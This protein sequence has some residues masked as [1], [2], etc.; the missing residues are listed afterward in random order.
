[1][2]R[3]KN[4]ALVEATVDVPTL[5]PI[6]DVPTLPVALRALHRAEE[7]VRTDAPNGDIENLAQDIF[8]HGLLHNL[9]GYVCED[10]DDDLNIKV[11]IV[12]GGRRLA[13]LE[14]LVE[15]GMIEPGHIVPVQIRSRDEA[16]EL[17]L[18]ENLARRD[19]NPVDEFRA[20]AQILELHPDT[21][22]ADLAKRFGYSERHVK[23][24][25]KLAE[26]ATEILEAVWERKISVDAAMAYA[27]TPFHDVQLRVFNAQLKNSWKP[28][29]PTTIRG[30]IR[31]RTDTN[32]S[33]LFKYVGKAAYE[34]AGGGY[35][36]DLFSLLDDDSKEKILSHPMTVKGLA[37]QKLEKD[38]P[39]LAK[40]QGVSSIVMTNSLL[41][42][43]YAVQAP[44]IKGWTNIGGQHA[45][46]Q[47][48]V[49]AEAQL[50]G[51][52]VKL[53]GFIE[54]SGK[55]EV[56]MG[57]SDPVLVPDG[58]AAELGAGKE[59]ARASSYTPPTPEERAAAQKERRIIGEQIRLAIRNLRETNA[60][61]G[62]I[63]PG[64]WGRQEIHPELGEVLEVSCD[65][66]VTKAELEAQLEAATDKVETDIA[67]EIEQ[68]QAEE[69]RQNE[70]A[71][72]LD[73][74]V[75]EMCDNPPA[76][77]V[78]EDGT[79][80]F[81]HEDGSYFDVPPDSEDNRDLGYED[82]GH[83]TESIEVGEVFSIHQSIEAYELSKLVDTSLKVE[84]AVIAITQ[85]A[86]DQG[87]DEMV[88]D[89][90]NIE[91]DARASDEG[92]EDDGARERAA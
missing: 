16:V 2:P 54:R 45:K 80:F 32:G 5:P 74:L 91:E 53:V 11:A 49:I 92:D 21:T 9:I 57:R 85:E 10:V 43:G 3:K 42:D 79:V 18:A 64:T 25:L 59:D 56:A 83:L 67:L 22:P 90:A 31:G 81:L 26:L 89:M 88:A 37:L 44:K 29:D 70:A 14:L 52:D 15:Q 73:T 82:I 7:N 39:K 35:E 66:F 48:D 24:R 68:E 8:A 23:Q 75:Q 6:P 20:F 65:I 69:A 34:K 61:E 55:L 27:S 50:I 1:M 51:A 63:L 12:G 36:D 78:R 60:L 38:L 17:S 72:Q 87:V 71:D 62:R 76:V 58:K 46:P 4:L 28:H 77:V 30:E 40:E 13:A 41:M 86:L 84:D 47:T 19:M 33:P